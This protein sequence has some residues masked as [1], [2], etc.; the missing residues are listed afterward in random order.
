MASLFSFLNRL[1]PFATPGTPLVQDLVHLAALCGVLYYGPQLQEW[2]QQRPTQ[3]QNAGEEPDGPQPEQQ[4]A[5][6]EELEPEQ[7][8]QQQQ[9]QQQN[10]E[11]APEE[12]RNAEPE[13]A[14]PPPPVIEDDDEEP[15]AGPAGGGAQ[16][17]P[18]NTPAHRNVGAK[19]A[20]S[21]A[22]R[23]QRR[24]YHEFQR[25][26]GDAQRAREAE[27]AE[28]REAAQNAEK[29]RRRA[30]EA[31][32]EEKRAKEREE[33]KER[34]RKLR[35]EDARRRELVVSLARDQL[36][37][38]RMCDLFKVAKMV[39]GDVDEE[40]IEAILKASGML[41]RKD[42]T[43]TMITG[44]GWAVRVTREDMDRTYHAAIEQEARDSEGR[45]SYEALGTMLEKVLRQHTTNVTG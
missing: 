4:G 30:A 27:G 42:D 28:A 34:E 45:I 6:A 37:E 17:G 24:A 20:K 7:Q 26:Q 10:I 9:Q 23:D 35:E 8:Q 31:K 32:L 43:M 14:R 21:L 1:L 36:D 38:E 13:Q 33:K 39:G 19:K 11:H 3:E 40:W 22:R 2:Y 15:E 25:A 12:P 29:E 41:G 5:G 44:M 18:A 16:A